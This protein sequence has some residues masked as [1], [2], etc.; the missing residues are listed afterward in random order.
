MLLKRI[1]DA[2]C[3]V[4]LSSICLS[5]PKA[6]RANPSEGGVAS[7]EHVDTHTNP[8]SK[9]VEVISEVRTNEGV[10]QV[11]SVRNGEA[12]WLE[13]T[14]TSPGS[15]QPTRLFQDTSIFTNDHNDG[16][17]SVPLEVKRKLAL[18]YAKHVVAEE[19][20]VEAFSR[21]LKDYEVF[22]VPLPSGLYRAALMELGVRF[23]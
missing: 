12:G 14:K 4:A 21:S 10:F 15:T 5:F 17:A 19:G 18:G 7:L 6:A 2:A 22:D 1:A 9:G 8:Q 20:G 16:G 11:L 23:P 3:V 13:I